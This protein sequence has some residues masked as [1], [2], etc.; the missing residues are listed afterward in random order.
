LITAHI[1]GWLATA[2]VN[3]AQTNVN[4]GGFSPPERSEKVRVFDLS[5]AEF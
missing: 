3:S 2:L 5:K 4:F 1:V